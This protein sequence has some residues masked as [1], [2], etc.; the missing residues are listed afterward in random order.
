AF[1]LFKA[2][3]RFVVNR[4]A[5]SVKAP[6]PRD[7]GNGVELARDNHR[8]MIAKYRSPVIPLL[9][10]MPTIN[11]F[12]LNDAIDVLGLQPTRGRRPGS[13]S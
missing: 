1:R 5:T 8:L 11:P 2:G 3:A 10:A 12:N 9:M 6:H 4:A 13:P 7:A